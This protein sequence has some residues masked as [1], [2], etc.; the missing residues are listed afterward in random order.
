MQNPFFP[1][2][3]SSELVDDSFVPF[4]QESPPFC[5]PKVLQFRLQGQKDDSFVPHSQ[6]RCAIEAPI[7]P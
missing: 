2:F 4:F 1:H 3:C 6:A 5:D 7:L